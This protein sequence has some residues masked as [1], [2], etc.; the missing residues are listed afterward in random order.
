LFTNDSLKR[1]SIKRMSK[2]EKMK[3]RKSSHLN[4]GTATSSITCPDI[5]KTINYKMT[6]RR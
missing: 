3:P 6:K 4:F 1:A 2:M 5:Q